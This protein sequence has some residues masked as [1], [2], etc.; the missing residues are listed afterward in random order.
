MGV[1]SESHP[2]GAQGQPGPNKCQWCPVLPGF[3]VW[4]TEAQTGPP[5]PDDPRVAVVASCCRK[6]AYVI[7][8]KWSVVSTGPGNRRH[9]PACLP[10]SPN[11]LGS[12]LKPSGWGRGGAGAEE[13]AEV[14]GAW[15]PCSY[16]SGARA[17]L[18]PV[19]FAH[20]LRRGASCLLVLWASV[21][22][23]QSGPDACCRRAA[24]RREQKP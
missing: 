10:A 15:H 18:G 4:E 21:H 22:P 23:P 8:R 7:T 6:R 20:W 2:L 9:H 14:P 17:G 12:A 19:R 13:V 1:P 16:S 24:V 5:G 3:Q 11:P